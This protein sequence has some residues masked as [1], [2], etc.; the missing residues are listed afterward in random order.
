MQESE[1][2]Q[3]PEMAE[4]TTE[5]NVAPESIET[6]TDVTIDPIYKHKD[7]RIFTKQEFLNTTAE[8][9]VIC[10]EIKIMKSYFEE[11]KEDINAILPVDFTDEEYEKFLQ[12][13]DV[14]YDN[15]YGIQHLYGTIWCKDGVWIERGEYDGAEWWEYKKTPTKEEVEQILLEDSDES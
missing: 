3:M 9:K 15:G 11:N 10:A 7:G 14:E 12:D 2:T 13:I 5:T 1:V 6:V 8:F 4:A